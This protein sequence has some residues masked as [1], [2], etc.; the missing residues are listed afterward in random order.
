MRTKIFVAAALLAASVMPALAQTSTSAVTDTGARPGNEIGTGN[1]LPRS[2]R[3]SNTTAHDT[4]TQ[5]APNLPSPQID[6][7]ATPRDYLVVAREALAANHTGQAQQSLEMADTRLLHRSVAQG[8]TNE[9]SN[10]PLVMRIDEARRAL[11][12]GDTRLAT[13]IVDAALAQ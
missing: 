1:S 13:Q 2:D 6:E 10:D 7:N 5:I 9:H 8:E 3:A 12:D 11:G 4:R